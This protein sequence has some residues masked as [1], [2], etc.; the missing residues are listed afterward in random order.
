MG[1]K[2]KS[3]LRSVCF[4]ASLCCWKFSAVCFH[5]GYCFKPTAKLV[6]GT[7]EAD[8]RNSRPNQQRARF[9]EGVALEQR[10]ALG[11]GEALFQL[12]YL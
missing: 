1:K 3:L 4:V 8:E 9:H 12:S 5:I 11:G 6:E 10:L 7:R 2:V